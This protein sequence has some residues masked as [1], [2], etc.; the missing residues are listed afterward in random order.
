MGVNGKWPW[1]GNGDG[2]I[3][4]S[5]TT[6]QEIFRVVNSKVGFNVEIKYPMI[7]ESEVDDLHVLEVN[8]Y[9]DHILDVVLKE[10]GSRDVVFSSFHPEAALC[11]KMKQSAHP[12]F[13]LT[14]GGKSL[15]SDTRCNSLRAALRFARRWNLTGVVTAVE[16]LLVPTQSTSTPTTP[17]LATPQL[18]VQKFHDAGLMLFT[19]GGGNNLV[20]NAMLQREAGMDAVIVDEVIRIRRAFDG[21]KV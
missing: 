9:T 18:I 21:I 1:K 11:A 19:Y 7:E 2:T 15:T 17:P 8:R 16:P 13:L 14:E 5:F 4:A 20:D 10:G 12:V 3:Q 6:L